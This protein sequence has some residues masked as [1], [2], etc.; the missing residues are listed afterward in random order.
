M[1]NKFFNGKKYYLNE[2]R[3]LRTTDAGKLLSHDVWNF[4]HPND[5]ILKG[6]GYV[7]H[8]DN[9]DSSDDRIE[10]LQKMTRSEH[11]SIHNMG[12]HY[13]LGKHRTNETKQKMSDSQLGHIVTDE[14]KQKI[15]DATL[16]NK[17]HNFGR[18]FSEVVKQ[19]MKNG[20]TDKI[21]QKLRKAKLGNKNPNY[22]GKQL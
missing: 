16:G 15:R 1:I 18:H 19:N 14:T 22:K 4:F 7:I 10:N 11:K 12:N 13:S 3:W 9:E 17:N 5:P 20:F 6:D 8:H 2:G 21:K